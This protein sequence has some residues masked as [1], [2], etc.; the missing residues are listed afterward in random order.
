MFI[1][2][3]LVVYFLC[4][5]LGAAAVGTRGALSASAH[6]TRNFKETYEYYNTLRWKAERSGSKH[7]VHHHLALIY[8]RLW[9]VYSKQRKTSFPRWPISGPLV[10]LSIFSGTRRAAAS[11]LLGHSG[12]RAYVHTR[13]SVVFSTLKHSSPRYCIYVYKFLSIQYL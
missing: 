12:S 1:A 11:S 5:G 9:Y 3:I 13:C 2:L 7:L 10:A 8:T 4:G 6:L